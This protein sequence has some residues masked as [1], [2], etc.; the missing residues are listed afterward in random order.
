MRQGANIT[1]GVCFGMFRCNLSSTMAYWCLDPVDKSWWKLRARIMLLVETDS[2]SVTA[3]V[4]LSHRRR[5][6]QTQYQECLSKLLAAIRIWQRDLSS[7]THWLGAMIFCFNICHFVSNL[8]ENV[9][10]DWRN[11]SRIFDS[12]LQ[13]RVWHVF[14]CLVKNITKTRFIFV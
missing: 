12:S 10:S 9:S 1:P 13:P 4:H 2:S 11:D 14:Y 3:E 6:G 8:N 7:Q 5:Q